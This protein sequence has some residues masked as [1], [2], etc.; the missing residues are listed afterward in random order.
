MVIED[1][2][3]CKPVSC[4]FFQKFH[5]R[6]VKSE[7]EEIMYL[8]SLVT[9]THQTQSMCPF[10]TAS[11]RLSKRFHIRIVLSQELE[12]MYLLSLVTA[13]LRTSFIWPSNTPSCFFSQR[14]HIL[15]VKS[16]VIS[17]P[18][19]EITYLSSLVNAILCMKDLCPS[20]N[21]FKLDWIFF[22]IF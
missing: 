7:E 2:C 11:C 20:M 1:L 10:N 6:M 12:T 16:L 8:L 17:S 19:P 22:S 21:K 13:K 3:P 14:F 5:I 15:I 4:F 18:E 9:T